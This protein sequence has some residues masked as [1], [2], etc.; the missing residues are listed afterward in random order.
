MQLSVPEA[1]L[2]LQV[3]E[4][5]VYRWIRDRGLPASQFN[6][7]YHLNKVWLLEWAH[8]KG[9]PLKLDSSEQL[10][11]LEDALGRG[12]VHF[13]IP[14]A[15]KLQ[16]LQASVARLPLPADVDRGYLYEMLVMRESQGSTGFG[17]G[18]A[19]PHTRGP[20]LLH[21]PAPFVA[22][23]Y[24]AQP[25]DFAA[26]DGQPVSA[27]FIQV[28]PTIRNHLHL[29]SRLGR[30][31]QDGPFVRL[32]QA[33][34]QLPQLLERVRAVESAPHPAASQAQ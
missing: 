9:I 22:V 30:V 2:L 16:V 34:A 14:G 19:I 23:G 26:Q 8:D 13:D 5:T 17:R 6:G 3:P 18:I 20:I 4:D 28:T 25:V 21:V 7:R 29:L 24:L 12:G 10:P 31:L 15:T 1:A 33:R 27:L 11:G 32:V